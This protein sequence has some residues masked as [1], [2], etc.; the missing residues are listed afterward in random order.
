MELI[1]KYEDSDGIISERLISD[2]VPEPP[3]AIT[4]F[5]HLRQ[6]ERTFAIKGILSAI[7][8]D[9][10]EEV[11]DLYDRFGL[12]SPNAKKEEKGKFGPLVTVRVPGHSSE[13]Y[14]GQRNKEKRELFNRF[15][16]RAIEEIYKNRFYAL[17][18]HQCL[19]C[20]IKE[21]HPYKQ[22]GPPV[23]CIDHHIPMIL[24]GHLVP[25]NLVA[26]C[27]SC[28]NKKLDRP[29]EEFYTSE[30]L[31][32]LKPIL[33]KQ[34]DIFDF[35]FDWNYWNRDRKSYLISLG[36]GPQTVDELLN[37]PN[38]PDY[39]G[40]TTLRNETEKMEITIDVSDLIQ[41]MINDDARD[42]DRK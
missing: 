14:K 29:P 36:V 12:P 3:A 9:S 30:E 17:F 21:R 23:L 18:N 6:Q 13:A 10:G 19:K 20:G 31:G 41:D 28:N 7:N 8:P 24:G 11:K 2:I 1:I 37:N 22:K 4:A 38:H 27:R 15:R 16:F 25:G 5:C 32:K 39:I 33:E 34:R 26:L 40:P 35:T 42:D